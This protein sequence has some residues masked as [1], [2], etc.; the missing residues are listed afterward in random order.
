MTPFIF[1]AFAL[2]SLGSAIFALILHIDGD[3][4]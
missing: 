4:Q 1:D 2:L 3:M